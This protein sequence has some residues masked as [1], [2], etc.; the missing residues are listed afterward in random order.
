MDVP[1]QSFKCCMDLVWMQLWAASG[2]RQ[3]VGCQTAQTGT[4]QRVSPARKTLVVSTVFKWMLN[5]F[6]AELLI[7]MSDVFD[8]TI[9]VSCS[10]NSLE[11]NK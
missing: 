5:I 6:F 10:P 11:K 7:H 3:G 2:Y 4:V 9:L 8:L 1:W